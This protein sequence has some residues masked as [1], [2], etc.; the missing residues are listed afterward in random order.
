[1]TVDTPFGISPNRPDSAIATI[2]AERPACKPLSP[3]LPKLPG[4]FGPATHGLRTSTKNESSLAAAYAPV[5]RSA[6]A[7][8]WNQ[9]YRICMIEEKLSGGEMPENRAASCSQAARL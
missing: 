8:V 2:S 9:S 4:S 3:G 6:V 7:G 1:M 5:K